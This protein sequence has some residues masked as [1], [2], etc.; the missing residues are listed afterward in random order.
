M[1]ELI[2]YRE[3]DDGDSWARFRLDSGEL[4]WMRVSMSGVVVKRSGLGLLGRVLFREADMLEVAVTGAAL[5]T[6][7]PDLVTPPEMQS[8]TLACFANAVMQ[9][10]S[11]DEVQTVFEGAVDRLADVLV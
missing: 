9:C 4:C 8:E 2:D 1:T 6:L 3:V 10:K 5:A 7:Y 11:A